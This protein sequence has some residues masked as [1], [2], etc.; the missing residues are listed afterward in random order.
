MMRFQ[1]LFMIFAFGMTLNVASARE[2]GPFQDLEGTLETALE[3][4]KV[5][6]P[7]SPVEESKSSTEQEASSASSKKVTYRQAQRNNFKDLEKAE[8]VYLE[9]ETKRRSAEYEYRRALNLSQSSDSDLSN[10]QEQ[11]N[12]IDQALKLA[13]KEDTKSALLRE[14][15]KIGAKI[16]DAKDKAETSRD[17]LVGRA[18]NW[19]EHEKSADSALKA[20]NAEAKKANVDSEILKAAGKDFNKNR[21]VRDRTDPNGV[22]ARYLKELQRD[23]DEKALREF[24]EK[25]PSESVPR[26]SPREP[27]PD[28]NSGS[29]GSGSSSS[30]GSGST[31]ASGNASSSVTGSGSTGASGSESSSVTGGGTTGASGSE[32]SSSTGSGS[33]GTTGSSANQSC[34]DAQIAVV[35]ALLKSGGNQKAFAAMVELAELKMVYRIANQPPPPI[36]TIE[37][38]V[39][40]SGLQQKIK[41]QADFEQTLVDTYKNYGEEKDVERIKNSLSFLKDKPLSYQKQYRLDNDSASALVLYLSKFEA[42]APK[43]L[44]F[45]ETDAA[46]LWALGQISERKSSDPKFKKFGTNNNL[47]NY[48]VRVCHQLS[49]GSCSKGPVGNLSVDDLKATHDQ[50][51]K[52]L[53]DA[54]QVAVKAVKDQ[55]PQCFT[56]DCDTNPALPAEIVGIKK[57]LNELVIKGSLSKKDGAKFSIDAE[58]TKFIGGNLT[59]TLETAK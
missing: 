3:G 5:S 14:K 12:K 56:G 4:T 7:E 26:L 18:K 13:T 51:E 37:K 42:N 6:Q 25:Y 38:Y 16:T 21:K 28:E 15:E 58:K 22:K 29:S 48:S 32:S 8:N 57:K 19:Q 9:A 33:T 30:T 17:F 23:A 53:N 31:G 54:I 41:D 52:E 24:K 44:E 39:S 45:T 43:G 59:L 34:D 49:D 36:N 11:V 35:E 1:N 55:Y 40:G 20:L 46:A 50:K 10:L 27:K 2:G 47:L